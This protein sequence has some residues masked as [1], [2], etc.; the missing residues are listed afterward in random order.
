MLIDYRD[1]KCKLSETMSRVINFLGVRVTKDRF[2]CMLENQ[3]GQYHRKVPLY[4]SVVFN[5]KF[6][7]QL[8]HNISL[9]EK[10]LKYRFFS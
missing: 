7:K 10:K 5:K 6:A 3:E 2:Q 9:V 4:Q 8:D 1:L